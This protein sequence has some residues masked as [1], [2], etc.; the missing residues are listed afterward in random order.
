MVTSI[1]DERKTDEKANDWINTDDYAES[2]PGS[3]SI[4]AGH[5]LD[6]VAHVWIV[7]PPERK[8]TP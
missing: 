7:T 1:D 3:V 8:P 5:P 2:Q 4:L 6:A